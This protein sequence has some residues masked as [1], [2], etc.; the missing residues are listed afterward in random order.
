MRYGCA[1]APVVPP[2]DAMRYGDAPHVPQRHQRTRTH[3]P[4]RAAYPAEKPCLVGV[5]QRFTLPKTS[6]VN[7]FFSP[8]T[9]TQ[10]LPRLY[11]P[12][13]DGARRCLHS[14]SGNVTLTGATALREAIAAILQSCRTVFEFVEGCGNG[15]CSGGAG[16]LVFFLP[17]S[18]FSLLCC[19]SASVG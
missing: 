15:R 11:A 2:D 1:R 7:I 5:R 10:R 13:T 19:F 6:V 16:A 3:T 9:F 8:L 17:R 4:S 12:R 14:R 18:S